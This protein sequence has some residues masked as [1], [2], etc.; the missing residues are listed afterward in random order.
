MANAVSNNKAAVFET[1]S[2]P[3]ALAVMS[4][5]TVASQVVSIAYNIADTWFIGRTNNS[6]MIAASS[7][8]LALYLTLAALANLFGAGGGNLMARQLGRGDL[9]AARK[10]AS[11]SIAMSAIAALG[12]SLLCLVLMNP[13]LRFLG[14]SDNTLGFARQ[15]TFAA[16]VLGG[17]PTVLSF[18]MPMIMRN[19]GYAK[20]A[21]IGVALGALV[22]IA[23]DPLLM[24]VVLPDGYQVLAA[25]LATMLANVISL[26][27]FI[28]VY[29][30]IGRSSVLE[31]P[32]RVERLD[33]ESRKSLY[34]VG[35]PAAIILFLF[36]ALGIV[37][38]VLAA[39]YDDTTLAA[40]G[41]VLK[42]ERLPQN[43][44]LGICLGM[45]PL[46]AYNYAR[47]DLCRMDSF[48]RASGIALL[49][50]AILSMVAFWLFAEAI[51]GAFLSDSEVIRLGTSFIRARCLSFPFML[52]GFQVVNFTQA[53]DKGKVSFLLTI[54]RH[55][56]L[57]IPMMIALNALLGIDGL[58]W[59]QVVADII[60]AGV[61]VLVYLHVRRGI[62]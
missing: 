9:E 8:V 43:T 46:V 30:R 18:S 54:I 50:V 23:L 27:Y 34:S 11:Y 44:G 17:V 39:G 5:P 28:I 42:V 14:A 33:A 57:S 10:T 49:S 36:S 56:V 52:V 2:V 58:M 29:R 35:V 40:V 26:A 16:V 48:F 31:I 12:F 32:R 55:L 6:Y 51:V 7:L 19:A 45:V 62:A 41:I 15:Y 24:F 38:N 37:L 59:S 25:G 22:N 47:G 20:E 4:L 60:N 53:V 13:M 1:M 21:G 61:S 3:R